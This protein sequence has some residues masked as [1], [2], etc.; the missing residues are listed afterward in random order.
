[1]QPA[2]RLATYEDLLAL[3]ADVRAEVIAGHLD[4]LPS[5]HHRHTHVQGALRSFIGRPFHDDDGY[6]GPG[7]WWI[8]L[9]TDVALS[10]H[11]IVRPDVS[12][13]RRERLVDLEE[14]P[15]SVVPDWIC[16]VLSPSTAARDRVVKRRLYA[17]HAVR[18]FWLIDPRAR[19]LEALELRAG[20]WVD[21]GS[22]GDTDGA[23]IA[24]FEAVE[25]SVGR[26]FL[27]PRPGEPIDD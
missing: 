26:L 15:I 25:L 24:P 4:V 8:V 18:H 3:D 20:T 17:E 23:R 19:T 13:F 16:E 27:P 2:S 6:G 7:G 9:E 22:Y 5:P 1:M 11:D 14:R 10:R 21:V 12:G